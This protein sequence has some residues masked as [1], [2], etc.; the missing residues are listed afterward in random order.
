MSDLDISNSSPLPAVENHFGT[1]DAPYLNYLSALSPDWHEAAKLKDVLDKLVPKTTT[2]SV[3]PA[4]PV[5]KYIPKPQSLVLAEVL[6]VTTA[7]NGQIKDIQTTARVDEKQILSEGLR[8]TAVNDLSGSLQK[9]KAEVHTRIFILQD[10]TKDVAL[11]NLLFAHILGAELNLLPSQVAILLR[12]PGVQ[13]GYSPQN[14]FGEASALIMFDHPD[15]FQERDLDVAAYVGRRT[16]GTGS[17]HVGDYALTLQHRVQELM[18][19]VIIHLRRQLYRLPQSLTSLDSNLRMPPTYSQ[20]LSERDNPQQRT[21]NDRTT[22]RFSDLVR[23]SLSPDLQVE[24]D[25]P[26]TCWLSALVSVQMREYAD[27]FGSLQIKP[28]Q[29]TRKQKS[30]DVYA[31]GRSRLRQLIDDIWVRAEQVE[32]L[33]D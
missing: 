6:D 18:N 33:N 31:L 22:V 8:A 19:L 9:C 29:R 32:T 10:G 20:F 1:P 5:G 24:P 4:A 13:F 27:F 28:S 16:M 14:S 11:E 17:P 12:I 23:F 21:T 2:S 7:S 26:V 15:M 25:V 30:Q 3:A